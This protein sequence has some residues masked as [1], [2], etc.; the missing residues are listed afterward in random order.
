MTLAEY[1]S[2]Q[3]EAVREEIKHKASVLCRTGGYPMRKPTADT[4]GY[5]KAA[6]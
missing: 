3:P 5:G 1:Q 2:H 4:P 6:K